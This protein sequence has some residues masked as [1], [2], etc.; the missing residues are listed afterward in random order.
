MGRAEVSSVINSS[1]TKPLD[2]PQNATE[3][4]G[5]SNVG[6]AAVKASPTWFRGFLQGKT[7]I[8]MA[9]LFVLVLGA[10]T[11][12]Y[13]TWPGMLVCL[14]GSGLRFWASGFLR[15]DQLLAVGGPY[16]FV[17][18]PLYLGTYLMAVGSAL[19]IENRQLLLLVSVLFALVYHF[20]ILDEEQKLRQIFGDRYALYCQL[21]PRFRPALWPA[22]KSQLQ[23]INPQVSHLHFHLQLALKNK[24]YEAF[25]SF[26]GLMA[27]VGLV[28]YVRFA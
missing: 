13:P 3:A 5:G 24:A 27:F 20:I 6:V 12:G 21:V 15:K 14:A 9:W 25:L 2:L 4:A 1:I 22:K 18:N 10:L 23:Q 19:A 8:L 16:G 26:A 7:R 11:H 17:R 28:A